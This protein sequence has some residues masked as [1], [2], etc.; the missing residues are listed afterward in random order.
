MA[1]SAPGNGG[2]PCRW[3]ASSLRSRAASCSRSAAS[4]G[5]SSSSCIAAARSASSA[6]RSRPRSVIVM[7]LRRGQERVARAWATLME[8]PGYRR[9]G[10]HGGD[11]GSGISRLLAAAAPDRVVGVHVNYLPTPGSADGL[12]AEDLRRLEKTRRLA[13]NRHPHQILFASRPQ[14]LAYAFTD[15]PAGQLAFLAEKFRRLD[16]PRRAP[17]RR[18]DPHRRH[19][20]LD[21]QDGG[22]LVPPG[23]GEQARRTGAVPGSAGRRGAAARHPAGRPAAR[24]TALRR[25]T[26]V[27]IRSRWSLRRPRSPHPSWPKISVASSPDVLGDQRPALVAG[28]VVRTAAHA[29]DRAAVTRSLAAPERSPPPGG[30]R[31]W[32]RSNLDPSGLPRGCPV[33]LPALVLLRPQGIPVAP[34]GWSSTDRGRGPGGWRGH[35]SLA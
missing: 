20:L 33:P 25:Q 1:H 2:N 11:W 21:H 32:L 26:V 10:A 24:R 28:R 34:G 29:E 31:E 27:R 7:T 17:V 13:A 35:N 16:R 12:G 6:A 30:L 22:V 15:S 23:E 14:T 19:A 4:S 5:A 18:R 3:Y 8:R 9:Y